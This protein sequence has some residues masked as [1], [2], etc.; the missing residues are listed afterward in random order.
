MKLRLAISVIG[1]WLCA[2]SALAEMWLRTD[3]GSETPNQAYTD[4]LVS[5][6][7]D[8][9]ERRLAKE[10]CAGKLAVQCMDAKENWGHSTIRMTLCKMAESHAW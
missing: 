2:G 7:F 5:N 8:A 9:A 1:V 3:E 4:T 6:C 10:A